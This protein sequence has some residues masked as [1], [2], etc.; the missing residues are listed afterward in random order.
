M[1]NTISYFEIQASEPKKLA[2]FYK[3][4]FGWNFKREEK[5]PIEYY[6]MTEGMMGAILK[7][8]VK[9]PPL[10]YGTNAF[11]CSVMVENF[12][13]TADIILKNGGI[14]A[15]PKFAVPS[16]CWQGY[17]VDPDHNVFGIFQPDENAK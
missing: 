1:L 17:F 13:R 7:R 3:N 5:M 4:V 8:P 9:T 15:M 10:E 16:R 2:E 14:V 12:D 11:T 6:R